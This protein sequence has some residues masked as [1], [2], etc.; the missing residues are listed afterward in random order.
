MKNHDQH[1][2][3]RGA[4]TPSR[5][6]H[7]KDP[8][9]HRQNLVWR[10][11]TTVLVVTSATSLCA[12]ATFAAAKKSPKVKAPTTT[13]AAPT[14]TTTPSGSPIAFDFSFD[15][16]KVSNGAEQCR[17]S[18][19]DPKGIC[20]S[21]G[22]ADVTV[23]GD[24][25]GSALYAFTIWRSPGGNAAAAGTLVFA[26]QTTVGTCGAGAFTVQFSPAPKGTKS[27]SGGFDRPGAWVIASTSGSSP[28]ATTTASGLAWAEPLP[29][30]TVV[31]H[32]SGTVSCR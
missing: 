13:V 6:V 18:G 23:T 9:M 7:P 11:L 31:G 8:N 26:P 27:P 30:E 24:V 14:T 19:P 20:T 10:V 29:D 2:N 28:L 32:F 5:N 1:E 16:K 12:P 17:Q 15:P 3:L 4:S 25:A 21:I 22:F